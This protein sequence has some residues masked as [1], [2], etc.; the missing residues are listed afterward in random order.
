VIRIELP[1]DVA[2][3]VQDV[4]A[5]VTDLD[6]LREWQPNV[7]SVTKETEGPLRQGTRLREV[8][9]GPFGRK[10]A[11]IVEVSAYEQNRRFDLEIVSGPLPIDGSHE[12]H[13]TDAG[14]RIEFVARG[15]PG[16]R[17]RLA[18]PLLARV[19]KRQFS[20]YY[21]RLKALLESRG[22]E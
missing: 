1:V 20:G 18:E 21:E 16:G 8:R 12:F 10:V 22:P 2:R 3:P 4:F 14:T 7:L 15:Q 5:Y 13:E 11:A 17:L 6:R 19:L 9:R